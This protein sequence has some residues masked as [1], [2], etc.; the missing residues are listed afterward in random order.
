MDELGEIIGVDRG[1]AM[2]HI[3]RWFTGLIMK[4]I[5]RWFTVVILFLYAPLAMMPAEWLWYDPGVPTFGD[6]VSGN[7][8]PVFFSRDIK[9]LSLIQYAAVLRQADSG[10]AVCDGNG[11]P[12]PYK[13]KS[14]AVIDKDLHWWMGGDCAAT[15]TPGH[16]WVETTWTVVR[17]LGDL[18]PAPLDQMFGW[19][20]PAK[21]VTRISP[22]FNVI[23]PE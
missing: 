9:R 22:V 5:G 3:G 8:I 14:G 17:P 11:G 19:I 4:H 16:Y 2:K 18:L 1:Q 13:P 10:I 20:I 12:F 6:V 23:A 21:T 15:L 7:P